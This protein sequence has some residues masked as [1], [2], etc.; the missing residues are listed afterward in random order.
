M[1]SKTGEINPHD[2]I[3]LVSLALQLGA[4]F[5][6]RGFSGD[7]EQLV[8]IIKAGFSHRGSPSSTSSRRA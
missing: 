4:S 8:P 6:A 1:R 3:D 7:K 5:V 2:S